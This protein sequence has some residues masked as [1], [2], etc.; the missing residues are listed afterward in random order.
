MGVPPWELIEKPAF[1]MEYGLFVSG[2]EEEV[3]TAK[4]EKA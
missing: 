4:K 1:W 2:V 3:R